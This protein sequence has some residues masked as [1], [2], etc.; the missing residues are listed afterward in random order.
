MVNIDGPLERGSDDAAVVSSIFANLAFKQIHRTDEFRH[1]TAHRAFI[2]IDRRAYLL[3]PAIGHD[4]HTIGHGHRL[5][6]V[7]SD[8]NAGN[9]H[10]FDDL[11]HFKLHFSAQFF[12]QCAH[13][14]V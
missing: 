9:A 1:H 13:G 3:N 4:R 2:N 11:D 5:F 10:L 14:L 8:H 12:I 7:V 6:L